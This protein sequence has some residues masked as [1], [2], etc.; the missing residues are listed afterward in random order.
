MPRFVKGDRVEV[1][2]RPIDIVQ[3]RAE[4][5]RQVPDVVGERRGGKPRQ[6]PAQTVSAP[7]AS[8]ES[9]SSSSDESS[10]SSS[11]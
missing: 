2:T 4:G 6:R 7:P 3:L 11:S 10:D 9:G 5:W 1:A 8:D